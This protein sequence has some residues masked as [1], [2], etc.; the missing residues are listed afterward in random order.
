M[1]AFQGQRSG[2][3]AGLRHLKSAATL[4][5][6]FHATPESGT[7]SIHMRRGS[8]ADL[9]R[10]RRPAPC[11]VKPERARPSDSLELSGLR[12][13]PAEALDALGELVRGEEAKRE[14]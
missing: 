14:A 4:E 5:P 1:Q 11:Y 10:V 13:G 3:A 9:R 6:L 7:A 12:E 8:A 2:A